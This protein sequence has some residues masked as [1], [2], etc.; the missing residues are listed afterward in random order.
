MNNKMKKQ[1]PFNGLSFFVVF[2]SSLRLWIDYSPHTGIEITLP[3]ITIGIMF[4][5]LRMVVEELLDENQEQ[6]NII[7]KCQFILDGI[8]A[9]RQVN[10][11]ELE[12]RIIK[13]LEKVWYEERSFDPVGRQT[14]L[15]MAM[16]NKQYILLKKGS[17]MA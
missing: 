11:D 4:F 7:T 8:M 12:G 14:K 10:N 3:F 17:T 2:T 9:E 5:N 16:L 13:E 6:S 1:L 15:M